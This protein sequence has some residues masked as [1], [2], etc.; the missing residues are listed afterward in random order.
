M[1]QNMKIF[2]KQFYYIQ[3]LNWVK[4]SGNGSAAAGKTFEDLLGKAQ[5]IGRAHV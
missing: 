5:E 4:S 2:C 3:A 1:K